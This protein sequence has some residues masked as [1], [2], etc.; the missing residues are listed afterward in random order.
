MMSMFPGNASHAW[1]GSP[2]LQSQ[3]VLRHEIEAI[4]AVEGEPCPQRVVTLCPEP[5][6]VEQSHDVVCLLR[7]PV[8]S[9]SLRVEDVSA[10]VVLHLRPMRPLGRL[11]PLRPLRPERP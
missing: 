7:R 9:P 1:L 10:L 8:K 6:I 2:R 3:Q 5:R 11:R 4:A